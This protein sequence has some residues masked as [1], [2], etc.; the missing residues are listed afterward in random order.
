MTLTSCESP[1]EKAK[2]LAVEELMTLNIAAP[3]YDSQLVEESAKGSMKRMQL[4]LTAGADVNSPDSDGRT[5]LIAA[6]QSRN[7]EVIKLLLDAGASV[8]A[9]NACGETA[10]HIA[11]AGGLNNII[12]ILLEKGANVNEP[13][14]SGRTALMSAIVGKNVNVIQ[15]LL[16]AGADVN[17][18]AANGA[19]ALHFAAGAGNKEIA[20]LLLAAG[21]KADVVDEDG[22]TLLMYAAMQSNVEMMEVVLKEGV[23][24]NAQNNTGASALHLAL[25]DVETVQYLLN[26]GS[27]INQADKLGYTPLMRSIAQR[28]PEV[29]KLLLE[30]KADIAPVTSA[31]VPI[32]AIAA[33]SGDVDMVKM[34]LNAGVDA[35]A[36]FKVGGKNVDALYYASSDEVRNILKQSGCIQR[37]SLDEAVALLERYEIINF[38]PYSDGISIKTGNEIVELSK[39]FLYEYGLYKD[40]RKKLREYDYIDS[41]Y[42]LW[43]KSGGKLL[44]FECIVSF[45]EAGS[46]PQA[47]LYYSANY[48]HK[49]ILKYTLAIPGIDVNK[50]IPLYYTVKKGHLECVK[51]LLSV[52]G[53]DVNKN[54][55]LC[56]AA[57]NGK[58]EYVKLLLSVPGIDV[59]KNAPLYYAAGNGYLKC[60]KLLLSVPGIDVNKTDSYGE[61]PLYS[62]AQRGHFESVKLLLSV[63]GID[64]NKT[65]SYGETPLYAAVEKGR[66]ECVKLLLSAPGIDVNKTDSY[67]KTPLHAAAWSDYNECV[68]LL[69][70]APGIDINKVDKNGSTPLSCVRGQYGGVDNKCYKLLKAAGAKYASELSNR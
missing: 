28:C 57:G 37:V 15:S 47:A 67:G 59:N 27:D 25:A 2:R 33:E 58:H 50:N 65:D 36:V 10:L 38:Y 16:N 34:L 62:A 55:P 46:L 31:G 35:T 39:K 52:P 17:A 49:S 64:V 69:L 42:R 24:V 54:A 23:C 41:I 26:A 61:T 45:L 60:V 9:K 56:C 48:G 1:E 4:L 18:T 44:P 13:D 8:Q 66:Q 22:N 63:P 53:I 21:A 32:I 3:Q 70:S 20:A 68:K 40:G 7:P 14:S 51:L 12:S 6:I 11:A 30:S 5:A 19:T 43:E 29:A